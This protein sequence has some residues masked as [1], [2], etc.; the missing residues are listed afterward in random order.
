MQLSGR[1][2]YQCLC[3]V[4][5]ALMQAIGWAAIIATMAMAIWAISGGLR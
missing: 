1:D 3:S 2:I 4:L 5:D